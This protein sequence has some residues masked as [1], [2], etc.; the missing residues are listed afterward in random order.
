VVGALLSRG[1]IDET[2]A[3]SRTKA[4]AALNRI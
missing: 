4:D 3:D 2:T 1:L